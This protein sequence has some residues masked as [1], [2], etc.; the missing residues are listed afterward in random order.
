MKTTLRIFVVAAMVFMGSYTLN[1]ALSGDYYVGSNSGPSG[2]ADYSTLSAAFSALNSGGVS[3]DVTLWLTSDQTTTSSLTLNDLSGS[4]TVYIRPYQSERKISGSVSSNGI[5]VF[6]GTDNIVV[7]GS[8]NGSDR[9]LT[10]ENNS[11]GTGIHFKSTSSSN[12]CQYFTVKNVKIFSSTPTNSN[13]MGIA[14]AGTTPTSSGYRHRNG[15]IENCEIKRAYYGIR[16]YSISSFKIDD[17]VIKDNIIGDP[18]DPFGADMI[19]LY[20]LYTYYNDKL[21][22]IGNEFW[23]IRYPTFL[24]RHYDDIK[25]HD[26][27]F[28]E[29]YYYPRTYYTY[30]GIDFQHNTLKSSGDYMYSYGF[31]FFMTYNY[32]DP[33]IIANNELYGEP[34]AHQYG[35]YIYRGNNVQIYNNDIHDL[36]GSGSY[37]YGIYLNYVSDGKVYDNSIR[38]IRN[39]YTSNW[40][41]GSYGIYVYGGSG[42][43]TNGLEINHN[44][45]KN[46][47]AN[48]NNYNYVFYQYYQPA[49]IMLRGSYNTKIQHNTIDMGTSWESDPRPGAV[50][51]C[52]HM[53]YFPSRNMVIKNNIFKNYQVGGSNLACG[54]FAW[55]YSGGANSISEIDDNVYD[56]SGAGA[57]GRVADWHETDYAFLTDWQDDHS[58]W[59]VNSAQT[60]VHLMADGHLDGGSID[61]AGLECAKISG[62]DYDMDGE[63]RQSTT[64]AGIDVAV[65]QPISLTQDML[66]D[67][68][69]GSVVCPGDPVS[70]GFSGGASF[71]DGIN[72]NVSTALEYTWYFK[73]E[74]GNI[75]VINPEFEEYISISFTNLEISEAQLEHAGTYWARIT[76]PGLEDVITSEVQ[77]GVTEPLYLTDQPLSSYEGCV[78]KGEI[79]MQVGAENEQGYI[80]EKETEYGWQPIEE[81]PND[82]TFVIDL[83]QFVD[84]EGNYTI[85]AEELNGNYRV[86]VLGSES[87]PPA[88]LYSDVIEVQLF[89]PITNVNMS[90]AGENYE[91]CWGDNISF[92]ASA[93]GD[94]AGYQW[95]K[96]EAGSWIDMNPEHNP[97]V[98]TSNLVLKDLN[99]ASSGGYRC[100]IV[101][102]NKLCHEDP[103]F[104]DPVYIEVP[105][106]FELVEHP[107]SHIVCENS[108]VIMYVLGNGMGDIHDYRWYKDGVPVE[109]PEGTPLE[110]K[111][112]LHIEGA[113]IDDIGNYYAVITAEDCRG[114]QEFRSDVAAVYILEDTE[115]TKQPVN[116]TAQHGENAEFKVEAH[117]KGIVPPYYQHDF[118]W[119]QRTLSAPQVTTML[120]TG[121]KYLGAKTEALTINDINADDYNYEYYAI[122][123][124]R[125]GDPQIS[126]PVIISDLPGISILSQPVSTEE[127]I[128]GTVVF[129]VNAEPTVT[130]NQLTYQW[131]VNGSRIN[132]DHKYAGAQTSSLTVDEIEIADA[133]DYHVNITAVG[134]KTESSAP[135]SLIV[136]TPP[137][138]LAEPAKDMTVR[139]DR[140][141]TLAVDVAGTDPIECQWYKDGQEIPG[142]TEA[143]F[144]VEY[145]AETDAG[146]YYA[147]LTNICGEVKS[148]TITVTVDASGPNSVADNSASFRLLPNVPNPF[149]QATEIRFELAKAADVTIK[150]TDSRGNEISIIENASYTAGT[151]SVKLNSNDYDLSSG[152]YNYTVTAN[153]IS[154]NGRMVIV[155]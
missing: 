106:I 43:T 69:T 17:I 59:D 45:I 151:Q 104:T 153:G 40:G 78:G 135:A 12:Y 75:S 111:K 103:V 80:W 73:D 55:E 24:Y 139:K 28:M 110:E 134:G 105:P 98:T 118:Q 21:D 1:A 53:G 60:E 15:L 56:L 26:N 97:T 25:I 13:S 32:S 10:I 30:A 68:P 152:V 50:S 44:F 51:A 90:D 150:L 39:T 132:D 124:G 62:I 81:A 20:G 113:T 109:F 38:N 49:G 99:S 144:E 145:A 115:I 147:S 3:G 120:E 19:Y 82:D 83:S 122:V 36:G 7:D 89:D 65:M 70:M 149:S 100:E 66:M 148:S 61:D 84:D 91:L 116:V 125:C 142:A 92:T 131:Y 35:F 18:D 33:F 71:A 54:I 121:D 11:T 14:I 96:Y 86:K 146:D 77:L 79:I 52:L 112:L 22:L 138:I 72:R 102:L 101:R 130:G 37:T 108:D 87:C 48:G 57:S 8:L 9:S 29:Y 140:K 41:G 143:A 88:Y 154:Y 34:D 126:D 94:F 155:K 5:L 107:E 133:G 129:E 27:I 137:E 6:N 114:V 47:T 58:G 93:E 141:L 64:T 128:N 136:N 67:P 74:D 85:A 4:G 95:Q 63:L 123:T 119:Y 16:S 2:P 46:I 31:Y 76:Y 127:C 23:G 117:M 42:T